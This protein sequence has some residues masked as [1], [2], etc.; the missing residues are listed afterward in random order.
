M[1]AKHIIELNQPLNPLIEESAIAI[2]VNEINYA[3]M[4]ATPDDLEVFVY[5]FLFSEGVITQV[6]DVHEIEMEY[7]EDA[8]NINVQIANRCMHK[9]KQHMHRLK[10]TSGC[11]LCGKQALEQA[12]PK[13]PALPKS[14]PFVVKNAQSLR[15]K[16][17]QYQFKRKNSGAIH[18]A[19]WIDSMLDVLVCKEDIGRHN[20]LD[21]TIGALLKNYHLNAKD[22][23]AGALL[24]SSRCS[25]ELIQKAIVFGANNLISLAS[26][27][28]LAVKLAQRHNLNL[29]H[30]PKYDQ[31]IYYTQNQPRI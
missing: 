29:I 24:V 26:P 10:G 1:Q 12:L 16:I 4:M 27:S 17:V 20:A 5:G 14:E 6:Y 30:L 31:A 3:V 9:L 22:K 23:Q 15:N 8:V 18:C 11:G 2:N 19:A 21:K 25:A 28:Q 13:L 7:L